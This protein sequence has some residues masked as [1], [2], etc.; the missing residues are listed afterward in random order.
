MREMHAYLM[1]PTR[2]QADCAQGVCCESHQHTI[3]RRRSA[4]SLHDSHSGALGGVA[5][6][7]C[8]DSPTRG[9]P[10]RTDAAILARDSARLEVTHE[11]RV[12]GLG[13]GDEQQTRRVL[14]EPVNDAATRQPRE[15]GSPVQQRIEQRTA[16][17]TGPG[18]DDQARRLVDQQYV[19]VFVNDRQFDR[20][21]TRDFAN[22][23]ARREHD[24]LARPDPRA[25][26]LLPAVNGH[27][28][29]EY[30]FLQTRAGVVGKHAG[31]RLIQSLTVEFVGDGA[32]ESGRVHW[33]RAVGGMR[34][35]PG[36]SRAAGL[37]VVDDRAI[38]NSRIGDAV[39]TCAICQA[40]DRRAADSAAGRGLRQG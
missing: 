40:P 37:T 33:A 18:M 12:C 11:T 30:P 15:F 7:R 39:S 20:L 14:V 38:K 22:L 13:P 9:Q 4:T 21:G 8:V 36:P 31:Q 16:R 23:M 6:D 17:V 29:G 27:E 5:T 19:V 25:G 28:A 10:A 24:P 34:Y 1:R 35:T 2:L 26:R 32:F 3:I